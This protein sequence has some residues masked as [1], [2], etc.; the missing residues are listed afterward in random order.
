MEE[1]NAPGLHSP[2][3]LREI[4]R[5]TVVTICK[6]S[7][8]LSDA[9]RKMV[10]PN[11]QSIAQAHFSPHAWFRAVYAG[12]TPVGF[13]MLYDNPDEPEY[14]LWRLMIAG[15]H[16]GKGYGRRAVELLI[17]YVKTRPGAVELL[18]S[19][20]EGE[21]SPEPFYRSLGFERNGR[22]EGEEVVMS[23]KLSSEGG[24]ND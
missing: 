10:A 24:P 17:D 5:D 23:L 13:I 6:L 22:M 2:V 16:Q 9:Q 19:C 7:D 1:N 3:S 11:G 20:R 14:Y 15:P 18:T 4:T 21:G 8:T 12:E